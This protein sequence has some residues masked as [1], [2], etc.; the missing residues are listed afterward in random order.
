[1]TYSDKTLLEEVQRRAVRF[2]WEK[3]DPT[4]GLVNDRSKNFGEDD[5][6]VAS[7]ASTGYGLAGLPIV[8]EHGWLGRSE[9]AARARTT[10]R[11][12]LTMP[13]EHGWLIHFVDRHTGHRECGSETFN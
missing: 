8:G 7:I 6:T 13:N 12:L 11:F 1:M 2:F 4:T 5:E 9:A 3:A 10:L